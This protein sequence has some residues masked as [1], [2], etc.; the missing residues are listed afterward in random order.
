[1]NKNI[2]SNHK[3]NR[4]VPSV[5][6]YSGRSVT[7]VAL[8]RLKSTTIGGTQRNP[9]F[10]LS[11]GLVVAGDEVPKSPPNPEVEL[12]INIEDPSSVLLVELGDFFGV[13]KHRRL[14]LKRH[15]QIVG[16][17]LPQESQVP[18]LVRSKPGVLEISPALDAVLVD[19]QL[20]VR[21]AYGE[22]EHQVVSEVVVCQ[23]ELREVC[24]GDMDLHVGRTDDQPEDQ[25]RYA[26]EDDE[27]DEDGAEAAEEAAAAA[28]VSAVTGLVLLLRCWWD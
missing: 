27:S 12:H 6:G 11:F 1:M 25:H 22:V 7:N 5:R 8:G 10:T 17:L 18:Q 3:T 23:V 4:A 20:L 21:V 15:A 16:G 28:P 2:N 24:V 19:A 9:Q 26:G 14:A 13:K